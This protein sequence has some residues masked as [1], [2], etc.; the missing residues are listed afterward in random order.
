MTP[1]YTSICS[2]TS[3]LWENFLSNQKLSDI[4]LPKPLPPSSL[5]C[6]DLSLLGTTAAFFISLTEYSFCLKAGFS[7]YSSHE[8]FLCLLTTWFNLDQIQKTERGNRPA[9]HPVFFCFSKRPW[10]RGRNVGLLVCILPRPSLLSLLL[11]YWLPD[12]P[13]SSL[14]SSIPLPGLLMVLPL[15]NGFTKPFSFC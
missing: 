1:K 6:W 14:C 8:L 13:H 10:S 5:S 15:Q 3:D 2:Y 12:V 9:A 7:F 4:P 11:S